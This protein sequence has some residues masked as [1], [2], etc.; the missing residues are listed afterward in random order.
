MRMQLLLF[1][2]ALTILVVGGSDRRQPLEADA[3]KPLLRPE[4]ESE[5]CL[6]PPEGSPFRQTRGGGAG[7]RITDKVVRKSL[8]EW[9]LDESAVVDAMPARGVFD[10]YPTFGGLA[11]DPAAGRAFFSDSSLS[12]VL[13]YATTAGGNSPD[14]TDP[15][16]HILGPD[17]GIGFIA[18][19]AVDPERKE[20]YAANND[21]GGV[22]IFSYD[23]TGAV[24]PVRGLET[25]HQSWGLSLSKARQ[26]LAVSVQ[27]LSGIVFYRR[28]AQHMDPP[29]R[30]LRGYDTGLADPHGVAFDDD[31]KELV[32]ANHGN[33]T[34]L[35]PYSPYDPLSTT[36][37][38]VRA[39]TLRTSVDPGLR[40]IR[41]GEREAA[42]LDQRQPDRSGLA[43][44]R[45]RRRA[46]R[47][48]RRG[49]LR[50]QF[51]SLF[52][53]HGGG[54]CP[55]H[56]RTEG[57]SDWNRRSGRRQGGP[58]A[59]RSLGRQLFGS[60]RARLRP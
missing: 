51:D 57:R 41:R 54:G 22:V 12:S 7:G 59:Q 29:V 10:P 27:Q 11:I 34:E 3:L 44:G 53:P 31:R 2:G 28:G 58:H 17:T 45:R 38:S 20:V 33:W 37:Q 5:M 48:D 8:Y 42:A 19:V 35:R 1:L 23:Q 18:G 14:I 40:R 52:P 56:A 30:T 16:T 46:A 47:R 50:R 49:E 13:S 21:G 39:R 43:D 36:P 4:M 9:P 24:R 25:P 60:L 55:A 15:L 26:E 32:V 6:M